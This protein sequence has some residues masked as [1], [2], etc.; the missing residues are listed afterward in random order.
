V[1]E[2]PADAAMTGDRGPPVTI[3]AHEVSA[4][5]GM[6]RQLSRLICGLAERGTDVTV[7]AARCELPRGTR[8]VR[9]IRVRGPRWPFVALYAWF[10]VAGGVC[11]R[12]HGRGLVHAT[13][14]IV[15][16]RVAVATVHYC[17]AAARDLERA[18]S[19]AWHHSVYAALAAWLSRAGERWCYHPG[20]VRRL[21]GVSRGVS[22]ELRRHF[23]KTG[24]AVVTIPNGVD[25]DEFRPDPRAREAIRRRWAVEADAPIALFVGGDWARKGLDVAIDALARAPGWRLVVAGRGDQGRYVMRAERLGAAGRVRMLEPTTDVAALFQ[26][27]DAFLLPTAYETFSLVTY[28][29]AA[30]GLPLLVTRV[31]GVEDILEH[32]VNGWFIA[33]DPDDVARHLNALGEDPK[34]R[35]RMGDAAR[36]ASLR[37]SWPSMI[38]AYEALY[39]ELAGSR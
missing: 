14:A 29:A 5:G 23:P 22:G 37:F 15:P 30:S 10:F 4:L 13:G 2:L 24:A 6:E 12:R 21:V 16:N 34:L 25:G 18:R 36:A 1:E 19:P 3:V 27:A 9:V 32:G 26:A 35:H 8:G 39:R 20:R 33:R 31:N 11:L 38:D 7:V 17:H 28:E